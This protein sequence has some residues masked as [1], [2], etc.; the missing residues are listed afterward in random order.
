M[1]EEIFGPV[2]CIIKFKKENEVIE[3]ANKTEYGL[4]AA[5]FTRDISR[6]IRM[7]SMID[8]GTIWVNCYNMFNVQ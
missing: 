7:T 3:M 1:K 5:M 4:A 8:A 6:A 2:G